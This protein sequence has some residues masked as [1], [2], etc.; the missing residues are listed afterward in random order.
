M[1]HNEEIKFKSLHKC[2]QGKSVFG[3]IRKAYIYF[4]HIFSLDTNQIK[5]FDSNL[6]YISLVMPPPYDQGDLGSCLIN[7]YCLVFK[8]TLSKQID[9][10][11]LNPEILK[12][13]NLFGINPI[14]PTQQT[15]LNKIYF[16]NTNE[17]DYNK[18]NNNIDYNIIRD[19]EEL[20]NFK[21]SRYYMYHYSNMDY[22]LCGSKTEKYGNGG[23]SFMKCLLL[24]IFLHGILP[25][26][27]WENNIF[28]QYNNFRFDPTDIGV[29]KED[30]KIAKIWSNRI[31]TKNIDYIFKSRIEN[32][33]QHLQNN[34]PIIIGL[35]IDIGTF[36]DYSYVDCA[37][38]KTKPIIIKDCPKQRDYI[39]AMVIIGY[40]DE[41]NC[42]I[43][44][45]SWGRD[46][47]YNGNAYFDYDYFSKQN[48][49][50]CGAWIIKN[51]L[52]EN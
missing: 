1:D 42:F 28:D 25:E 22:V 24:S 34:I 27:K 6:R 19:L 49:L 35:R 20:K 26:Q 46:W 7:S 29:S 2:V 8:Y 33:K 31:I 32:F 52:L 39:H 41:L 37:F 50:V 4:K 3:K 43:V 30:I 17:P 9:N 40:D 13:F 44:R 23:G 38:D 11:L 18:Q 5:N 15:K 36:R 21:P 48:N 14:R 12:S 45:N 16:T 51:I 47:G 10:Y